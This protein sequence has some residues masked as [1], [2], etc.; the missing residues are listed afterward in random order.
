MKPDERN[1][2]IERYTRGPQLLREALAR[3][4][5]EALQWRPAP[6]KWS[7]H[8]VVGHCADSETVSSTRIRYVVGEDR[9][10]IQGYDQDRWAQAFDYHAQPLDLALK[11]VE[12]V[13]AWTTELIRRL[14]DSAWAREATH[15]ESGRYLA[16]RWLE[17][18]AEHLEVHA[19]QI[20]R[21]VAAWKAQP[22]A[23]K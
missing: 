21:I 11:Q 22:A 12:Q 2:L 6:G 16:S 17:L 18:Y 14:P 9:P 3:V 1:A 23:V 8:E 19:R 13:R 15:T 7:A 5:K 20:D 4:P 10:T